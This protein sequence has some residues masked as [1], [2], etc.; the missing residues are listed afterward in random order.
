[1]HNLQLNLPVLFD[2]LSD[3]AGQGGVS[4]LPRDLLTDK[5]GILKTRYSRDMEPAKLDFES[6]L[7][8]VLSAP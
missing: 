3:S 5:E 2:D 1:M 7:E 6:R 4:E 8:E